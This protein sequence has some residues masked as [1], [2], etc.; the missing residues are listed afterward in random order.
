[1]VEWYKRMAGAFHR[2]DGHIYALDAGDIN[3]DH[4]ERALQV[5]EADA[6][7]CDDAL[8]HAAAKFMAVGTQYNFLVHCESRTGL[9]AS[10]PYS[11]GDRLLMHTRDFLNMGEC[12][13]LVA[14]RRGRGRDALEPHGRRHHGRRVDRHHRLGHALHDAR[15]LPGLDRRRGAVRVAT[16]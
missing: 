5:F 16:S 6:F 14:R 1:M 7:E 11:L 9:A 15:G 13:L 2:N 8:R 12:G 3:H 4:D 10:G